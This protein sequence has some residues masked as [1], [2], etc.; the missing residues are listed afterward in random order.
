MDINL[1]F[2]KKAVPLAAVVMMS[3]CQ[4]ADIYT[5][6]TFDQY[7]TSHETVAVVPFLVTIDQKNVPEG[8]DLEALQSAEKEEGVVF[9]RQLYSQFLKR[10]SKGEYTVKFQDVDETN[11]LLR[12][13]GM[14][15][16]EIENFTKAEIGAALGVDAVISG[17][18]KRDK[19][20]S[21]GAAVASAFLLGFGGA[22]NSVNVN[23]TVHDAESGGLLWSY[24][25]EF[26]GGLGSSAEGVSK[27]LLKA[28]SKKFPYKKEK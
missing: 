3:A 9:Q 4:T 10:Y 6:D 17:T 22:T 25:H 21:T 12:R 23:M 18:I 8:S 24:D 14:T 2:A 16:D 15:D 19:P 1:A 7:K 28:S 5:A 26:K 13:A 20:M 11:V 27:E